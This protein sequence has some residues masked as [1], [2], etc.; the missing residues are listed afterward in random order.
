MTFHNPTTNHTAKVSDACGL[1]AFFFGAFYFMVHG[2]WAHVA[3]YLGVALVTG[4]LAAP[5]LWIGYAVAAKQLVIDAYAKR[6][7]QLVDTHTAT[8]VAQ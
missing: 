7:Y 6:G 8:Q 3:I 2:I 5:F 1:W 4:G